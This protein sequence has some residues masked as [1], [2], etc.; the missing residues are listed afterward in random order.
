MRDKGKC[1]FGAR[2]KFSHDQKL[3][4]KP[5]SNTF[6]MAEI[7]QQNDYLCEHLLLAQKQHNKYKKKYNFSKAK[8]PAKKVGFKKP[9][10]EKFFED[11]GKSNSATHK[12]N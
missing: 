2:C 3:L 9:A 10:P 4:N 1:D 11:V 8:K 7:G 12:V 5:V 6:P